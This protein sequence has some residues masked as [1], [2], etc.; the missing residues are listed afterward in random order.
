MARVRGSSDR[1]NLPFISVDVTYKS[2][3]IVLGNAANIQTD[4]QT[5]RQ[6]KQMLAKA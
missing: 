2:T 6:T 5:N 1:Q 3:G 4:R